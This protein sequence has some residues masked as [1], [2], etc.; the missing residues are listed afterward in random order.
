M[1][2][3]KWYK[4]LIITSTLVFL[5]FPIFVLV[6]F[7]FNKSS[8]NIRWEGFT[9]YWYKELFS[10]TELLEAFFNTMLVG[11]TSTTIYL[12]LLKSILS[13]S[14]PRKKNHSYRSNLLYL[15]E[16]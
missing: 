4:N 6:L 10:N 16:S 13:P 1:R 8:L 14:Y 2:E 3:K 9:F 15:Q 12:S 5:Y 11:I 7:S